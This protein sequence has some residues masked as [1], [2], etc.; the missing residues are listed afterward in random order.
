MK[1]AVSINDKTNS[2]Y[3]GAALLVAAMTS[4]LNEHVS[5]GC[6]IAVL[7][8]AAVTSEKTSILLT[9]SVIPFSYFLGLSAH[10]VALI[11]GVALVLSSA[12]ILMD[13]RFLTICLP[14]SAYGI[15]LGAFTV[16]LSIHITSLS[17]ESLRGA[18]FITCTFL[19]FLSVRFKWSSNASEFANW[20]LCSVVLSCITT[21]VFLYGPAEW[22]ISKHDRVDNFRFAGTFDEANAAGRYLLPFFI[23]TIIR[24]ARNLSVGSV[25]AFVLIAVCL[26]ATM[27]KGSFFAALGS[28]AL[29][30]VLGRGYRIRGASVLA[31]GVGVMAVW[32]FAIN[33]PLQKRTAIEW[34]EKSKDS[35]SVAY[36]AK[37]PAAS[38][39]T[40]VI[41][42][43]LRVGTSTQMT[44]NEQGQTVYTEREYSIWRTGQRDILWSAG[45]D[46]VKDNFLWGIGYRQWKE[47]MMRRTAFPFISP[48]NGLLEVA[49]AYGVLGGALYLA[50]ALWL[51]PRSFYRAKRSVTGGATDDIY[52]QWSTLACVGLIIF[53]LT[54][55]STSLA[56]TLPAIWFWTI[57]AI[58]EGRLDDADINRRFS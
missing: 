23:L 28:A 11:V 7:I 8:A 46:V 1:L 58:H 41:A 42:N 47:E 51:I 21:L 16:L 31:A 4:Y 12:R 35:K 45:F 10:S 13:I 33:P 22:L 40:A 20:M 6:C 54:D 38:T 48:H 19:I 55:V 15:V 34:Q 56:A 25:A 49:G 52:L 9:L 30:P 27:S 3:F 2:I 57:A 36:F 53:E 26:A 37:A 32:I 50:L 18:A 39:A 17:Q 43:D 29:L 24:A 14:N 5:V 44:K